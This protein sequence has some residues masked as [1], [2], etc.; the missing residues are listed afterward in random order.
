MFMRG[1]QMKKFV[2]KNLKY[3]LIFIFFLIIYQFLG[4]ANMYG[5]PIANY[6]FSHAIRNGEIPYVDFNT[7]STPLY[8]FVMS[9]GLYLVDNYLMFNIEQA[10]LCTVMFYFLYKLYKEK[11]YLILFVMTMFS[12]Y[13]INPTYNFACLFLLI[14]LLY[15]EEF[16]KDKDYLI[17][18]VIGLTILSKHTIGLFFLIPTLLIYYKDRKKILRRG[19]GVICPIAVFFLYLVINGAVG[20]FIDLCFLGLFDFSSKNARAFTIWFFISLFFLAFTFVLSIKDKNDISRWYLFLG[21]SFVVPLFDVQHFAIYLVIVVM[22]L[23]K[24]FRTYRYLEY[25]SILGLIIWS[26]LIGIAF[27]ITYRPV[28]TKDLN[29]FEY[30]LTSKYDYE[31]IKA[32]K[33]ILDK[34]ENKILLSYFSMQYDIV[35]D[36]NISYYDVLLYGNFGYDGVNKMIKKID[37]VS[38]TYIIIDSNCYYDNSVDSQ[39]AKDIVS[40]VIKNYRYIKRDG[41]FL[42]Y[43]KD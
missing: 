32:S 22:F 30:A 39:F 40:Y 18:M 25:F 16:H 10:I 7:I 11:S 4:F 35:N 36:N 26:F 14:L 19:I 8:A 6:G 20:S 38:D 42:I 21:F 23:C 2:E 1:I 29:H 9:I 12:F 5:D 3:I 31:K 15:L 28:R 37:E 17:G 43:Y 13:A 34:Y 27:H 33:S 41:D 24:Y